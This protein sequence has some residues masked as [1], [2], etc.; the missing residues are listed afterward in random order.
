VLTLADILEALTGER[1]E[2]ASLVI[3]E[4]AIDSRQVIP[5]SLFVALPGERVDGHQFVEPAFRQGSILAL[6]QQDMSEH[7]PTLDLRSG[8]LP[9]P[10]N[11][12]TSPFCILVPD[13]LKAFQ[14]IARFWRRKQK[15]RVIGVTGSIG[16]TTTKEMIAEVLSQR[17]RTLKSPGN[18]NNETSLPLTILRMGPGY[19][20]AVL[21]MGFYIP[22]EISF[23]CD[24]ALPSVG[25][26]TNVTAVHVE[27][28]GSQ[29]VIARG[30]AELVQALPAAPEGTA[31]LNYDDP[32]VRPMA[33]KTKA[34]VLFYGLDPAAELW[35]DEVESLGLDGIRLRLHFHREVMHLRVPIIGRHSV[36]NV[37]RTVA[38][39]LVENLSWPEIIHGLQLGQSQLRLVAVHTPNGALLLDDSYNATP[40]SVLGALSLLQELKG[41][42]IAVL[43]EMLEL[44]PFESSAHEKVGIKAAEVADKLVLLGER[45][46]ILAD[47]AIQA[48]LKP[49]AITFV[50]NNQEAV[51]YLQGTLVEGDIA[52]IKGSHSLR[53]DH[54]VAALESES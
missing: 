34:K 43:G 53:M 9:S 18:L 32:W 40:E 37:L 19:E 24:L 25:V 45:T 20:R 30:K 42:K 2:R 12:P 17:Y 4:A 50:A 26:V 15:L 46:K 48:G 44:G 36:H 7:F 51:E 8:K 49:S 47:S 52:L 5:A 38:V 3:S 10:L 22:G 29:E 14:T 1:P 27:R 33:E 39:G 11:I 6:V 31:I 23:L 13:S 16:K 54:I 28:A 41:R 21:E 35:A